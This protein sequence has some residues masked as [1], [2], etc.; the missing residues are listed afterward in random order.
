MAEAPESTQDIWSSVLTQL[1]TDDRITPQLQGF[2][3]LVEPKGVMAGTLYLE[4]PNELTR[5]MLEQRIRLP[6]LSAISTL[7]DAHEVSTFAIVVNPEIQPDPL[8]RMDSAEEQPYIETTVVSA[9]L[10]QGAN[11]RKSDSRLN[12]KYSFDNFVIGASNR[13]AHAAAVAVAEAPAKAYNPLF[14]YGESGL[15]KTHLL[16]AIGHYTRSL[17]PGTR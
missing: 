1:S 6:L 9:S 15:G 5:G 12:P 7:D 3:S 8:E 13:F 2:I 10:D 14:I 17:Y 4:V 11:S 16:H